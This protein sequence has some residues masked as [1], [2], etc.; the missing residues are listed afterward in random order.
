MLEA[1]VAGAGL[2]AGWAAVQQ[3]WEAVQC[4]VALQ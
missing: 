4:G 3:L 1:A 2:A